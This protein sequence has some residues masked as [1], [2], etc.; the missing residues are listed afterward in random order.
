MTI[1]SYNQIRSYIDAN[2]IAT[3]GTANYHDHSPHGTIVYVCADTYHPV[4][5]FLTKQQTRKYKNLQIHEK[6]CLTIVNPSENSTLQADGR[7]KEIQDPT[8]I[9]MVMNKLAHDHVS[10]TEWLP[11]I[12][13]LHAGAY[14]IIGITLTHARLAHFKGMV[15]GDKHIFTNA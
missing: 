14:V 4:V 9:N 1:E 2:P 6:V 10:A 7:A 5:Y 8:V 3:I 11:P 13:K 12:A 15:I